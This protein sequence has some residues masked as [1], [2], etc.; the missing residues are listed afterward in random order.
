MG[1]RAFTH[2]N[3]DDYEGIGRYFCETLQDFQDPCPVN[4]A[5]RTKIVTRL[6]KEGSSANEPA[7]IALSD[8]SSLSSGA[9]ELT[10]GDT[11][12]DNRG[13]HRE[14]SP[15]RPNDHDSANKEQSG[16][17]KVGNNYFRDG[18]LELEGSELNNEIDGVNYHNHRRGPERRKSR[19]MRS[20]RHRMRNFGGGLAGAQFNS[21]MQNNFFGD[22]KQVD[23]YVQYGNPNGLTIPMMRKSDSD[24]AI[25]K[26]GGSSNTQTPK[27]S[28]KKNKRK[29]FKRSL[30]MTALPLAFFKGCSGGS[31]K[32]SPNSPTCGNSVMGSDNPTFKR[33]DSWDEKT[34][35]LQNKNLANATKFTLGTSDESDEDEDSAENSRD[36]E[37]LFCPLTDSNGSP[38]FDEAANDSVVSDGGLQPPTPHFFGEQL[39]AV[40]CR[41]VH[42]EILESVSKIK[43]SLLGRKGGL[44]YSYG[45]FGSE[46]AALNEVGKSNGKNPGIGGG[47]SKNKPSSADTSPVNKAQ[48]TAQG[49]AGKKHAKS[50]A[51]SNAI[52][53]SLPSPAGNRK[54]KSGEGKG[55]VKKSSSTS[56]NSSAGSK[57]W[58]KYTKV[59]KAVKRDSNNGTNSG[60]VPTEKEKN[61][62]KSDNSNQKSKSGTAHPGGA[63]YNYV[64][65][66]SPQQSVK[67][68]KKK[69]KVAT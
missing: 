45:H 16:N 28:S 40:S 34:F 39:S 57:S 61:A 62:V 52:T 42:S 41:R 69:K 37:R 32:N 7:N 54:S 31:E 21:Q 27:K 3:T 50:M 18:A 9:D 17:E 25:N 19:R 2:F 47:G 1:S 29:N 55:G 56:S 33:N 4:D 66:S 60:N 23:N 38:L 53:V 51:K 12:T 48:G 59:R 22:S 14:H 10:G 63:G 20:R 67:R 26:N 6:T 11:E 30:T 35:L 15:R 36:L 43:C 58:D 13:N 64:N 24:K 49:G 65:T 5:L 8:Y 44:L 46:A 68:K